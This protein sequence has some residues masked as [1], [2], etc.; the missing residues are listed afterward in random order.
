MNWLNKASVILTGAGGGLGIELARELTNKQCRIGL[1]GR[2]QSKLELLADQLRAD[3][4][5]VLVI[6]ADITQKVDRETIVSTM[7]EH[8]QG[9]DVLINNAGLMSFK[10]IEQEDDDKIAAIINTNITSVMQLCKSV[11]PSLHKSDKAH[12]VNIGSTFGSIAFAY[13]TSY[14]ASKFALRGFSEA[15]R[16]ELMDTHIKVSYFAPRAVKTTLNSPKVYAMAKKINMA[17]DEP[18]VIA[19]KVLHALAKDKKEVYFGFPESLFVRINAL[20]PRLVDV[21]LAG[22]NKIMKDY[23]D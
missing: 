18:Q 9:I 7:I 21:A 5:D 6:P 16:R 3:G 19:Q 4:A 15:L 8:F 10:G 1:V 13:Y 14:S 12:I 23:C 2:N 11:L 20:F 22:Q 17:M